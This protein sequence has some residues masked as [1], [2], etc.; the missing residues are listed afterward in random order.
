M[1]KAELG[2]EG[3]H[4]QSD[5][6]KSQL[7]LLSAP[8]EVPWESSCR[9]WDSLLYHTE[10]PGTLAH[11]FPDKIKRAHHLQLNHFAQQNAFIQSSMDNMRSDADFIRPTVL[12]DA[13]V[14]HFSGFVNTHNNRI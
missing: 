6:A 3:S 10:Y 13:S 8:S 4:F 2:K 1:A 11:M 12:S 7:L 9:F 5:G 14:F